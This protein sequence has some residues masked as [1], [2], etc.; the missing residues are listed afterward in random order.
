MSDFVVE[1]RLAPRG[2]TGGRRSWDPQV[3]VLHHTGGSGSEENQV[4]YLLKNDRF[5][6]IHV[7][8]AKSGKR[9]R[10]VPD[11][12]IAHHVGNSAIGS[13]GLGDGI[14]RVTSNGMSLG[15]E[16]INSGSKVVLDPWPE[17]QV[18]SCAEQVSEWLLKYDIKMVTS[19]GGIDKMGKYD[20][21]KFPMKKFWG[22]V[23]S[24]MKR[25]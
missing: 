20:P 22:Y 1:E 14:P 10:M 12:V 25:G 4:Q 9:Y 16:L 6:S 19:H 24:Y 13:I 21:Y 17:A 7:C 18:Q 11:D 23:G 3:V 15:I 2:M 5:V 8:I